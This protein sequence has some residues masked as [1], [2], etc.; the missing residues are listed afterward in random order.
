MGK[1][2]EGIGDAI[3]GVVSSVGHAVSKGV[4]S[5]S[6][7][8]GSFG[9]HFGRGLLKVAKV[10]ARPVENVAKSSV[11]VVK[12]VAKGNIGRAIADAGNIASG[13]TVDLTGKQKG[14]VN[15][16]ATKYVRSAV[17]TIAGIKKPSTSTSSAQAYT[18]I[19]LAKA[20]TS[21]VMQLRKGRG[22]VGGGSYSETVKNP[23]GG[24][25][26]KTGK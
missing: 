26:G 9:G 17:A 15:I 22:L 10:A 13:G 16:D 25:A 8:L 19:Q 1:V 4:K 6:H 20:S 21:Q 7:G 24:S 14:I 5:I 12:N 11:N 18:P 23:L 2:V 3:G